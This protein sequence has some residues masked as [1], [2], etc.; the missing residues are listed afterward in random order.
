VAE[1]TENAGL[2]PWIPGWELGRHPAERETTGQ[3]SRAALPIEMKCCG[4]QNFT[5][6]AAILKKVK[7]NR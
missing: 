7:S 3:K 4:K 6:L 1:R 2:E 5:F